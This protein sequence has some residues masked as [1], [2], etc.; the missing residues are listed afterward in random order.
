MTSSYLFIDDPLS[1][2]DL[3]DRNFKVLYP[4][5]VLRVRGDEDR[6][7]TEAGSS[8]S[9]GDGVC[10][11]I[12]CDESGSLEDSSSVDGTRRTV[13]DSCVALGDGTIRFKLQITA[14]YQCQLKTVST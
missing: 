9:I 3:S 10:K 12:G 6:V 5:G 11:A 7:S 8:T 13:D 4:V 1:A 2:G 14:K